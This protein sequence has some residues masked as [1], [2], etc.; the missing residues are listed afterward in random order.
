M[1]ITLV[2]LLKAIWTGLA[3]AMGAGTRHAVS[4]QSRRAFGD[5]FPVGTLIINLSGALVIGLITAILN[6]HHA[7]TAW[8]APLVLGFVGGYT[9]FSTMMLEVAR[10][11]RDAK[12]M[13]VALYLLASL[14]LGPLAAFVGLA[15]G[16]L[17]GG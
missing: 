12:H 6:H 8:R 13:R 16:G 2:V 17:I 3:G 15:I 9:T 10:L 1:T 5:H 7:L 11:R 14:T 4:V